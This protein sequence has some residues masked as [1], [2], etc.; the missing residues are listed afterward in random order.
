MTVQTPTSDST[1]QQLIKFRP[2]RNQVV[3]FTI[4]LILAIMLWGWVTQIQDPFDSKTLAGNTI[5]VGSLPEDLQIVTSL[6]DARVTLEGARS[7]VQPIRQSDIT[8]TADT[9]SVTGPG[10]YQVPVLVSGADVSKVTVDPGQITL[11]VDERMSR[12]VPVKVSTGESMSEAIGNEI[13]PSVSQVT[14]SGPRS[15]VE[16]VTEV[17]LP[18]TLDEAQVSD[19]DSLVTPYAVDAEGLRINEVEILP[20]TIPVTVEVQRRGKSISVIPNITGVPAEGY[21]IQVRRAL[22]DTIVVDGPEEA[23]A[24]LLFVNTEAVDVTDATRSISTTVGIADLPEGVTII[25]PPNGQIE[26]RVA[27]EDTSTSSQTLTGLPIAVLGLEPGLTAE[28]EPTSISI[29]V[30]APLDILQIMTPSDITVLVDLTGLEPGT[31]V[32]V[33]EV[34][35]PSGATWASGDP[36]AARIIVVISEDPNA[37]PVVVSATPQATPP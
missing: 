10:T 12:V 13:V 36:N 17:I 21:T 33:P 35:L 28:I 18:V 26:V 1:F 5:Q 15:A 14:V 34:T 22:P 2:N 24:D 20:S 3:S 25:D 11:Q 29:Q 9:S 23:L 37:T 19:Y 31:H 30:S 4:S 6:P 8:V 27:I 16:R 7:Q 32:I